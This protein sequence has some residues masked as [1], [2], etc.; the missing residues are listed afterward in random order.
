MCFLYHDD[1]AFNA[2][3]INQKVI[4]CFRFHNKIHKNAT[5]VSFI[6]SQLCVCTSTDLAL[7]LLLN[8][9]VED[10]WKHWTPSWIKQPVSKLHKWL[11]I[12]YDQTNFVFTFQARSLCCFLFLQLGPFLWPHGFLLPPILLV[13]SRK[14][15]RKVATRQVS[16]N[17]IESEKIR[18]KDGEVVGEAWY[19]ICR[20]VRW[21]FWTLHD[22]ILDLLNVHKLIYLQLL[23]YCWG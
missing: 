21:V 14:M 6:T 15:K 5:V 19:L 2:I 17:H 20:P 18:T 10:E 22:F 3:F 8:R 7:T 9:L 13:S 16:V 4:F 11:N 23:H 1:A 12:W